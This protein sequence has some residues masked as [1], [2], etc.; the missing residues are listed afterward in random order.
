MKKFFEGKR[1][2]FT[3][4]NSGNSSRS[5]RVLRKVDRA[6]FW[7]LSCRRIRNTWRRRDGLQSSQLGQCG[8]FQRFWNLQDDKCSAPRRGRLLVWRWLWLWREFWSIG[9]WMRQVRKKQCWNALSILCFSSYVKSGPNVQIPDIF[10]CDLDDD[11]E[12]YMNQ[13]RQERQSEAKTA[14]PSVIASL[15]DEY[16]ACSLETQS[17][18]RTNSVSASSKAIGSGNRR[19]NSSTLWSSGTTWNSTEEKQLK[20]VLNNSALSAFGQMKLESDDGFYLKKNIQK[21]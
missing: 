18:S 20:S 2:E 9:R 13:I 5:A 3:F 15:M 12:A 10:D 17:R 21:I 8:E 19:A 4:L 16:G 11:Y 6:R 1:F 14:V 7:N